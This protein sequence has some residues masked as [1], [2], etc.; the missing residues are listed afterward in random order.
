M[1]TISRIGIFLWCVFI[2]LLAFV[3]LE[4]T[5]GG[6]FWLIDFTYESFYAGL[7]FA[8]IFGSGIYFT[9]AIYITYSFIMIFFD[10]D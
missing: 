5:G 6:M 9:I 2:G 1:K 3:V 8:L 4:F 10:Y 7:V